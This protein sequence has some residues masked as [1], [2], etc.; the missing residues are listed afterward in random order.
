[1]KLKSKN[2]ALILALLLSGFIAV[3]LLFL[4]PLLPSQ[5]Y[6]A[7]ATLDGAPI[8]VEVLKPIC[9]PGRYY[10]H[11]PKSGSWRYHWFGLSFS[12]KSVVSP[13]IYIGWRGIPYIHN[14]QWGIG[15]TNA[16]I[17]DHWEVNFTPDG[18]QFSNAS[19][20][21]TLKRNQ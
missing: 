4:Q 5:D 12:A 13:F 21:I 20:S 1:M 11:L 9:I 8:P 18:V 6:T 19:L 2:T 16:K 15:L 7:T 10:L 14:D 3:P 17:E